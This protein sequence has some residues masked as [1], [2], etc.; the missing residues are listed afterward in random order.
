M[1]MDERADWKEC[2]QSTEE[3]TADAQAFKAAF[4]PFDPTA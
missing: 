3:D 2:A 1:K 4:A